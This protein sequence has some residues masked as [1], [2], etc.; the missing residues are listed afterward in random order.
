MERFIQIIND[1]NTM[2]NQ[3]VNVDLLELLI[4][5][6]DDSIQI[7]RENISEEN[8]NKLPSKEFIESLVEIENDKE[9][10]SC[11]ICLEEFKIGEK[12]IKL[13]CKDHPHYFHKGN[14]NCP[15]IMKWFEKSNTCPVCRTEFPC[16]DNSIIEADEEINIE[17]SENLEET[18][19]ETNNETNNETNEETNNETNE[20][21]QQIDEEGNLETISEQQLINHINR[22]AFVRFI[23][24]S[25]EN[26]IRDIEQRELDAAIQASLEE[27]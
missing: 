11:S 9:N 14:D 20:E 5:N 1:Q 24:M 15:G 21:I 18:N 22:I 27:Q 3:N 26:V 6:I 7:I 19:E 13:P 4:N 16:E 10:L 12:C 23:N 2:N 25:R 8:Q 17:T